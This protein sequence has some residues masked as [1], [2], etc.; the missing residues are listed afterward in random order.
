MS[1]K[2]LIPNTERTAEELRANGR[3]GGLKSVETRRKK[4]EVRALLS[5]FLNTP[6]KL[7]KGQI[8]EELVAALKAA[9]YKDITLKER[10]ALLL[11]YRMSIGEVRA[12]LLVSKMIGEYTEELGAGDLAE[13]DTPQPIVITVASEEEA[14]DLSTEYESRTV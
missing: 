5:E 1:K 8:P 12:S 9:G 3:K 11:A 14:A 2:G 13:D 7:D 6:V 10:G 4:K